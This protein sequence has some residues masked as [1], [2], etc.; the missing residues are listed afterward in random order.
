[1]EIF[2]WLF[3]YLSN[4]YFVFHGPREMV[5]HLWSLAVEEQF[6]LAWPWLILFLP[7]AGLV[8]VILAFIVV[9]PLTRYVMVIN[10]FPHLA[11]FWATPSCL[12]TLGIGALLAVLTRYRDLSLNRDSF[13]RVC[14]VFG[15]PLSL[16][17]LTLS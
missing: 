12:D 15:L 4:W 10:D 6:Y 2:W 7:R 14:L 9:A 1:R 11:A 16:I 3:S 5:F 13:L 17:L 8:P